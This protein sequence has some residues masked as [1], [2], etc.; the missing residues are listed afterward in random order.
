MQTLYTFD[1][2]LSINWKE[3]VCV[4]LES[5]RVL[6]ERSSPFTTA[7]KLA[8]QRKQLNKAKIDRL[9]SKW[10]SKDLF[11]FPLFSPSF[12]WVSFGPQ[13]KHYLVMTIFLWPTWH[14]FNPQQQRQ[15]HYHYNLVPSLSTS[16]LFIATTVLLLFGTGSP[17]ESSSVVLSSP[18]KGHPLNGKCF[19][20][21]YNNKQLLKCK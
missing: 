19:M 4:C 8:R 1:V 3:S 13:A 16:T 17:V 21:R 15:F 5:E 6:R 11:P 2:D 20:K 14:L 12:L 9:K 18:R 7:T 10:S